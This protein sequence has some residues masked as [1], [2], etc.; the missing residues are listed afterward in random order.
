MGIQFKREALMLLLIFS[1]KPDINLSICKLFNILKK[2]CQVVYHV[3]YR[4]NIYALWW[5]DTVFQ[6]QYLPSLSINYVSK[7]KVLEKLPPQLY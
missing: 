3:T 5:L 6:G 2:N 1:P 7:N 4:H